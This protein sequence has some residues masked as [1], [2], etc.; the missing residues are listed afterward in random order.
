MNNKY[1]MVYWAIA[2]G[3]ILS[4]ATSCETTT[5]DVYL[6]NPGEISATADV[7]QIQSGQTITYTDSS[8]KVYLRDWEFEGGTPFTSSEKVVTVTYKYGGE[9]RTKLSITYVDNQVDTLAIPVS[10]AGEVQI[11]NPQPIFVESFSFYTEYDQ[12]SIGEP[13]YFE[14]NN[15]FTAETVTE[16]TY[17]GDEAIHL[18]FDASQA[19][20]MASIKPSNGPVDISY[21]M[22]GNYNIALKSTSQ[23]NLLLRLQG[24]GEKAI[25]TLDAASEPYGFIRDGQ[26]YLLQIPVADF[27]A[28]NPNLDL[29]SITDVLVF[30]SDD[31]AGIS[32]KADFDFY[33]DNVFLSK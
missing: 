22:D 24:G 5:R 3:F 12:V 2:L 27:I 15:A 33:F 29:R 20:A 30:R 14:E 25:L 4:I 31:A 13:V 8:T 32:D 28:A 9:F 19:W 7:Y 10:V 16:K 21:F 26:W 6:Y 1:I 17:E 11:I 23:S 18:Q